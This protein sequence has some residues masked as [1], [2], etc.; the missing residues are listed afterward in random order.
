MKSRILLMMAIPLLLVACSKDDNGD[1]GREETANEPVAFVASIQA[2][3]ETRVTVNNGWANLSDSRVAI[4]VDGTMKEYTVNEL[5]E[6]TSDNPFYWGEQESIV[7]DAWYPFNNGVKPEIITVCADQS[8]RENYEKSDYL[9]V[10]RTTVSPRK[11]ELTFT[12]RTTKVVCSLD[13]ELDEAKGVK[14]VFKNLAGVDEGTNVTPTDK[15]RALLVPQ[16]IPA[17]TEFLEITAS[18]TGK[19]I[20][21]LEKDLVLKKGCLQQIYLTITPQGVTAL[22]PAPGAWV[23]D[24]EELEGQSPDAKPGGNGSWNG[25]TDNETVNG[26]TPEAN[27]G[28]GGGSWAGDNEEVEAK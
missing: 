3:T 4:V 25:S 5:G 21:T 12:H 23:A 20:Y 14:V 6:V 16:T 24:S 8:I 1:D 26:E 2:E 7:V 27:S 13:F 11:N 22:F 18:I 19:H 15:F 17:G 10:L 28:N 9:E